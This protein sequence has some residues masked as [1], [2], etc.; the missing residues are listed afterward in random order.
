MKRLLCLIF[1]IYSAFSL[2]YKFTKSV[3]HFEKNVH[4]TKKQ[5]KHMLLDCNITCY[6]NESPFL[7]INSSN[8]VRRNVSDVDK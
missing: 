4:K 7:A 8:T 3:R 1:K 5:T 6:V 2:N